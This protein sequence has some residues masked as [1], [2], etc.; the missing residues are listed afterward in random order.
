MD[1]TDLISVIIP[2]YNRAHLI[3]RSAESVLNQTY[4][5]LE[6]IIV[7]DGSTD[8]TKEVVDSL[9]DKRIV[10]VKQENQG[11]CAARN[12]GIK[13]AKGKY[14]AFQDSD[15]VWHLN[16]LEKQICTLKENNA[17]V[18]FCKM[19]IFGNLRKRVF[20]KYFKNGFLKK[21]ELPFGIS[22]QNIFG[23]TDIFK[24]NFFDIIMQPI[25]D[26]ELSLR[27]QQIYSIYCLDEA[28]VDYH[29]QSNSISNNREKVLE[30]LEN[31]L[32]K[33]KNFLTKYNYNSLEILAQSF[34]VAT[35][36]IKDIH[37]RKKFFDLVFSINSSKRTKLIYFL[38]KIHFYKI[39]ESIV[40]S[41]TIPIKNIISIFRKGT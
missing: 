4:K 34:L 10:Y 25:E 19:F 9:N 36:Q 40:K 24:K 38:N 35:F 41:I 32:H 12:K 11:A 5:N 20:P 17:D 14:I 30:A 37:K 28:L 26:F 39:R 21:D 22:T 27:I 16:K 29:N 15:D 31:I 23:K 8:N 1:S 2:T 33:D 3:K 13:L 18:V 7:D 6:L